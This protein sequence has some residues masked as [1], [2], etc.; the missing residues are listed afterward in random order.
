MKRST[1]AIAFTG[2]V[3]VAFGTFIALAQAH[4]IFVPHFT[5][6]HIEFQGLEGRY[7]A[8]GSMNYSISLEG[9]GS[10]CIA[11][12][13]EVVRENSSLPEE[14]EQAAYYGQ[15]QDCRV[16]KVSEGPYNYTRSFTYGGAVLGRPGNYQIIVDVFDQI[17]RQNYTDSSSFI[18]VENSS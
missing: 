10:N 5:P 9:Y 7:P 8:N 2:A 11:F 17:T 4:V 15:I 12:E 13:A 1:A 6:M 16:I 14:E 18:V 3:A